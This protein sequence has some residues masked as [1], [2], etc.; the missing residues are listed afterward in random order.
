MK[1]LDSIAEGF[2][3]AFYKKK[4]RGDASSINKLSIAEAYVVQDLVTQKRIEIG[5]R[6]VGFKVGCTSNAIREQFGINEPINGKLFQPHILQV[7][8]G[9]TILYELRNRT[10]DGVENWKIS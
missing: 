1:S 8:Q 10:R 9:L 7:L 2:Y 5:E 6:V 4:W 3:H